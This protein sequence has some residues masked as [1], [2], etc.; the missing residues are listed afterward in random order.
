MVDAEAE[1]LVAGSNRHAGVG[2][3]IIGRTRFE[4]NVAVVLEALYR[5]QILQAAAVYLTM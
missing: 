5:P 4:H 1:F 3:R 2:M